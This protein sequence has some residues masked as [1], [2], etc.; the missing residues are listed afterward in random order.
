MT[1][2][3]T[4]LDRALLESHVARMN[5]TRRKEHAIQL[6][7]HEGP[8][9]TLAFPD[10]EMPEGQCIDQD[11]TE[12]QWALHEEDKLTTS[13]IGGRRDDDEGRYFIDY[14]LVVWD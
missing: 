2:A 12:I 11:F 9:F 1:A 8:R 4:T 14:E 10:R 7:K 5:A 3:A 6:V 13:I